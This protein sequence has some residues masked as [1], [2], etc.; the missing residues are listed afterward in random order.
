MAVRKRPAMPV[1]AILKGPGDD[2]FLCDVPESDSPKK[3]MA[4]FAL[5]QQ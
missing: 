3:G 1:N 4:R 5:L 2:C